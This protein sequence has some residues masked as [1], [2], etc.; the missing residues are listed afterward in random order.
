MRATLKTPR[1]GV[2]IRNICHGLPLYGSFGDMGQC[3]LDSMVLEVFSS[4]RDSPRGYFQPSEPE[5]CWPSTTEPFSGGGSLFVNKKPQPIF[6]I[7]QLQS[8]WNF[9]APMKLGASLSWAFRFSFL[10]QSKNWS[11]WSTNDH[12]PYIWILFPFFSPCWF[13]QP[14]PV[15]FLFSV[16][17]D[18]KSS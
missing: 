2:K 17:L 18:S 4:L 11:F 3:W 5:L 14:D 7:F 12:I 1:D 15:L 6:L 13:S 9:A 8:T 16:F 10:L